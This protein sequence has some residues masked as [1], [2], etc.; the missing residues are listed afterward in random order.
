[1]KLHF[2]LELTDNLKNTFL[3]LIVTIQRTFVN[4]SD[5]SL[6]SVCCLFSHE[7]FL[8]QKLKLFILLFPL[9]LRQ[10]AVFCCFLLFSGVLLAGRRR[11][12]HLQQEIY[13]LHIGSGGALSGS[14]RV[15]APWERLSVS[16]LWA[17]PP[18]AAPLWAAPPSRSSCACLPLLSVHVSRQ[19]HEAAIRRRCR[20][21][22]PEEEIM[23]PLL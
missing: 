12:R 6:F 5:V 21:D 11:R 23:Q 22:R 9:V 18:W 2:W 7:L 16:G 17:A 1:M 14:E 20:E 19:R 13:P 4:W 10:T 15:P 3:T 8:L